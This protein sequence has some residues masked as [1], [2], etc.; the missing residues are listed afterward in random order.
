MCRL[1]RRL[2]SKALGSACPG[3]RMD[4]LIGL[5]AEGGIGEAPLLIFVFEVFLGVWVLR[6]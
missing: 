3:S 6:C 2:G 5:V 4:S 1:Y